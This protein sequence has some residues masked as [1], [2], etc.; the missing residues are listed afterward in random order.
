MTGSHRLD[1]ENRRTIAKAVLFL[2]SDSEYQWL[3][4]LWDGSV[5]LITAFFVVLL[6]ALL[7][8]TSLLIRFAVSVPLVAAW[9]WHERWQFKRLVIVGDKEAWPFLHWAELEAARRQPRL[10]NGGR[11]M[12]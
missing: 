1:A 4:K 12:L 2:Q 10:L 6:F 5:F 3:D 9:Q 8:E 11:T 7:P